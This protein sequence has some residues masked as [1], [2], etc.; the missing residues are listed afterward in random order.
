LNDKENR[1]GWFVCQSE[2]NYISFLSFVFVSQ[3][4]PGGLFS[5]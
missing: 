2:G 5:C 1:V 3:R 4:K